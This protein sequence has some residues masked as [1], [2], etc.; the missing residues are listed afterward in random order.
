MSFPP[1]SH[2]ANCCALHPGSTLASWLLPALGSILCSGS[3][4]YAPFFQKHVYVTHVWPS[5]Q[6]LT[7]DC[8]KTH[9]CVLAHQYICLGW[10]L[11]SFAAGFV[12]WEIWLCFHIY[13]F[14]FC[15][16]WGCIWACACHGIHVEVR[17][18]C[19]NQFSISTMWAVGSKLRLVMRLGSLCFYCL[20]V[21]IE[22]RRLLV[23]GDEIQKL[24]WQ[25]RFCLDNLVFSCNKNLVIL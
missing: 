23:E 10:H 9:N 19:R 24:T 15:L 25:P 21:L 4:L 5:W 12:G 22:L 11:R 18:T 13:F 14:T 20:V 6:C 17:T 7:G 1:S 8:S 3:P 2:I 16:L